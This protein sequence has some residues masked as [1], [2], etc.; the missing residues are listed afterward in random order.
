MR[1][2]CRA[3][4]PVHASE[5]ASSPCVPPAAVCLLGGAHLARDRLP[6]P[7]ASMR[8]CS[9]LWACYSESAGWLRGREA[10][11]FHTHE[12]VCACRRAVE[13]RFEACPED[14]QRVLQRRNVAT[15]GSWQP[16]GHAGCMPCWSQVDWWSCSHTVS[17]AVHTLVGPLV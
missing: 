6:R 13:R 3:D 1:V 15:A 11:R 17:D 8:T 9:L 4:A 10:H 2:C 5:E 14:A 7:A 12:V 16:C